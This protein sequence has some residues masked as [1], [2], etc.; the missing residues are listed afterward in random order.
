MAIPVQMQAAHTLYG[1]PLVDGRLFMGVSAVAGLALITTATTGGHPTLWNPVGSGVNISIVS[2]SLSVKDGTNAFGSLGWYKTANAGA[3]AATAAPI[4]TF[5]NVA[6]SPCLVGSAQTSKVFWS[7]TTNTFTAAPVYYAPIPI[8]LYPVTVG[9]VVVGTIW[10]VVYDG[11][12]GLAPGN[13]L[14]ICSV[15]ATTTSKIISKLLWEEIP[16]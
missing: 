13:A 4:A 6:P 11:T 15:E 9:A 2:L 3:V 16:I 14:S 7:P 12:L 8:N 10:R 1:Q 5:T